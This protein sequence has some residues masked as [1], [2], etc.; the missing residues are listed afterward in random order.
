MLKVWLARGKG[1]KKTRE[2]NNR[3]EPTGKG[4]KQA[5]L[6]LA[7]ERKM[8]K[9]GLGGEDPLSPSLLGA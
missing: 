5:T 7:W 4:L 1:G 9:E 3:F 8:I 2:E 6:L